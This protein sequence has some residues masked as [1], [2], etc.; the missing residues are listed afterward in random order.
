MSFVSLNFVQARQLQRIH[1]P[2]ASMTFL[3]F[4]SELQITRL[5]C[6]NGHM[7]ACTLIHKCSC[8]SVH[9]GF[10][11]SN[12]VTC[13][14]NFQMC[15]PCPLSKTSCTLNFIELLNLGI[16]KSKIPDNDH[17][18]SDEKTFVR[19]SSKYVTWCSN[20][21]GFKGTHQSDNGLE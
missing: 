21:R 14:G 6:Y 18:N 10:S 5:Y 8:G 7:W 12:S 13:P 11:K 20:P 19:K 17:I 2:C 15:R 16:K 9:I 1:P 4:A 3:T